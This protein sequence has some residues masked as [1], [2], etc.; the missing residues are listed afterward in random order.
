MTMADGSE[1]TLAFNANGGTAIRFRMVFKKELLD[2]ITSIAKAAGTDKLS[3]LLKAAANAEATGIDEISLEE[4]DPELLQVFFAI[5]GS[6]ELSTISQL[7]Y[8]MNK[9][10]EG[11]DMRALD[12]EG[13]LDW[14][15]QF[16]TMEFLTHAM[17]FLM[18]YMNNKT[19]TSKQKKSLDQLTGK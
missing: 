2:S 19:T 13:Y 10:A 9:S 8:I 3:M 15:E 12:V 18:L 14:L 16:E 1:K 7:A 5:A 6:G 17:D 11:A 4:I